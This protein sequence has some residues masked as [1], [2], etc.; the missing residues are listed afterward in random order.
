MYEVVI[1]GT[2]LYTPANSISNAE[3]VES[4]NAY[5]ARFNADNAAAIDAGEVQALT[6]LLRRVHREGLGHQEPLRGRQ[7]RHARPAASCGPASPSA[8]TTSSSILAEMAR[9]GR[10]SRPSPRWGKPA[11]E[12]DAVICAASNMQRAYPAMAIEVQQA[13]GIEG[14]AFDM[15]VACSS[16]T[17]GIKTAARLRAPAGQAPRGADGQSGDLLRPPQLPRPRQPLHLRRRRPP[18]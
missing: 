15:N 7:G 4:F 10:A 16:A 6:P 18:P 9:R 12:I 14:F 2:G 5:V 13:L 17:F 8:P 3:L 11:A 1:G